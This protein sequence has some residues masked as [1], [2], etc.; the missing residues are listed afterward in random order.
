MSDLSSPLLHP[1]SPTTFAERGVAVPFI[2]PVLSGVRVRRDRQTGSEYLLPNPSGGRGVYIVQWG[3]VQ[4]FCRPGVHDTLLHDAIGGL[5]TIRPASL[6][7]AARS[8]A[9]QGF[10][11]QAAKAAAIAAAARDEAAFDR[12]GQQLSD[13]LAVQLQPG[14]PTPADDQARRQRARFAITQAAI[15][16]HCDPERLSRGLTALAG[17]YTALG[18]AEGDR[19]ARLP[20]LLLRISQLRADLAGWSETGESTV[21]L[22][23]DLARSVHVT[24][25]CATI[26]LRTARGMTARMVSLLQKWLAAPADLLAQLERLDWLMDG[27]ERLCLVWESAADTGAHRAA[28]LEMA[29]LVPLLPPEIE[30]WIGQLL[31]PQA[32]Q[33]GWRVVSM[34]D[35]WRTGS[36]AIALTA[37]NERLRSLSL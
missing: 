22:A 21:G 13:L 18:L 11:G 12:T 14:A 1:H 30:V 28:L 35:T 6:R 37:R 24:Q 33:P 20:A 34:D 31:G 2:T 5:T 4:R 17:P 16:L 29:Q 25:S 10:A 27:W 32:L 36:A 9:E 3:G 26:L 23:R 19:T 8:V 7:L 15:R